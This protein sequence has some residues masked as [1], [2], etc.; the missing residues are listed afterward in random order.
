MCVYFN[1]TIL[2]YKAY[3]FPSKSDLQVAIYGHKRLAEFPFHKS[4]PPHLRLTIQ[5]SFN[6]LVQFLNYC[7]EF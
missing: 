1:Y 7:A 5:A 2:Q 6:V 4:S 3:F